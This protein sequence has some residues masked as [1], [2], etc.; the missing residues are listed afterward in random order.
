MVGLVTSSNPMLT[1]LRSPP[2]IPLVTP[3]TPTRVF[4]QRLSP[5]RSMIHLTRS[6]F[7]FLVILKECEK[8]IAKQYELLTF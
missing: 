4:W 2:E 6:F 3:G 8:I 5:N 1:R 7:S